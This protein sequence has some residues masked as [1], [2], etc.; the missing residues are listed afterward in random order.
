MPPLVG[1]RMTP[2][3]HGVRPLQDPVHPE[4]AELLGR[5]RGAGILLLGGDMQLDMGPPPRPLPALAAARLHDVAVLGQRP[6]VEGAVRRALADQLAGL[7]RGQRAGV[8]QRLEQGDPHRVGQRPHGPRIGELE[9]V[10]GA[11]GGRLG[12]PSTTRGRP[13]HRAA[14]GRAGIRPAVRSIGRH[15]SKHYARNSSFDKTRR[16]ISPRVPVSAGSPRSPLPRPCPP[17]S[18]PPARHVPPAATVRR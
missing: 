8:H 6:E 11:L 16:R 18:P 14:R 12:R 7:G 3:E 2:R 15:V 1:P 5:Q 13:G 10:R 17:L 9:R 4:L